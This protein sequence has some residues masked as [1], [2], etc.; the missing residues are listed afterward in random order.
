MNRDHRS[1]HESCRFPAEIGE[2]DIVLR[3]RIGP[4]SRRY[5]ARQLARPQVEGIAT[6]SYD[7]RHNAIRAQRGLQIR[8]CL[9]DIRDLLLA[10]FTIALDVTVI[11]MPSRETGEFSDL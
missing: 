9:G 11:D 3:A 1:Q 2:F 10:R 6:A 4:A 5:V 7:V 8:H